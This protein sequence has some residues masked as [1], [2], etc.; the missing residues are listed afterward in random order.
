[1]STPPRRGEQDTPTPSQQGKSFSTAQK[2][3]PDVVLKLADWEKRHLEVCK[4]IAPEAI[5]ENESDELIGWDPGYYSIAL[6][7]WL[8][9]ALDLFEMADQEDLDDLFQIM[10]RINAKNSPMATG[11]EHDPGDRILEVY[12]HMC[13]VLRRL[14]LGALDESHAS[15]EILTMLNP[16]LNPNSN[17]TQEAAPEATPSDFIDGLPQ[18]R[19]GGRPGKDWTRKWIVW[20]LDWPE[21]V[22][23]ILQEDTFQNILSC[24]GPAKAAKI[25]LSALTKTGT[26]ALSEEI[27]QAR[28]K[29]RNTKT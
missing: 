10:S 17:T 1:M 18:G 27:A 19:T 20:S 9:A 4:I 16:M 28:K 8:D 6:F 13:Q 2:D 11:K 7:I 15:T 5:N 25:M 24:D 3:K 14:K 23:R 21:T 29:R 26:T 12:E 22:E